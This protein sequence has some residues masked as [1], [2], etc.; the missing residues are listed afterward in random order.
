MAGSDVLSGSLILGLILALVALA[1]VAGLWVMAWRSGRAAAG[2]DGAGTFDLPWLN[3]AA[4]WRGHRVLRAGFASAVRQLRGVLRGADWRY[5]IPWV[6]V[7]GGR[8]SGRSTLVASINLPRQLALSPDTD[9]AELGCTWNVFESGIVLEPG[10]AMLWKGL[11]RYGHAA[12]WRELMNLLLR[13]RRERGID[14]VVITVSAAELTTGDVDAALERARQLREYLRELQQYLGLRVPA[15]LVVTKCDLVPGFAAFWQPLAAERGG[16]MFG[17]SNDETL[18]TAYGSQLIPRAFDDLGR[19][20]HRILLNQ[21]V[22]RDG[23]ADLA[24]LFPAE[25]QKLAEPVG[26]FADRLFHIDAFQDPH[27]FRGV[28]FTGDVPADPPAVTG[29]TASGMSGMAV[30][31]RSLVIDQIKPRLLFVTDLFA[32]K[33]FPEA[34]LVQPA[35]GG[36]VA[37]GRAMRLRWAGLALAAVILALGSWASYR[38]VTDSAERI[39]PTVQQIAARNQADQASIDLIHPLVDAFRAISGR[40]GR[41]IPGLG[42]PVLDAIRGGSGHGLSSPFLPSS[43]FSPIEEKVKAALIKGFDSMVIDPIGRELEAR[44]G[45]DR[46]AHAA[47]LTIE[48]DGPLVRQFRALADTVSYTER[49]RFSNPSVAAGQLKTLAQQLRQVRLVFDAPNLDWR[50][51]LHPEQDAFWAKQLEGIRRNRFLGDPAANGLM[52]VLAA[53]VGSLR[54]ALL[55]IRASETGPLVVADEKADGRLRLDPALVALD[56]A[57]PPVLAYDFLANPVRQLVNPSPRTNLVLWAPEPL[58]RAVA[59]E[60]SFKEMEAG[61]LT[62]VPETLRTMIKAVAAQALQGAMVSAVADAEVLQKRGDEF[63][64]FGDEDTLLQ[65]ARQFGRVAVPLGKVLEALK[66]R[67]FD[68]AHAAI[69]GVI[70]QHALA[71]LEQADHLLDNNGAWLPVE[72]FRGWDGTLPMNFEGYQV[73]SDAELD[74]YLKTAASRIDWLATEIAKPVVTALQNDAVPAPL[75]RHQR[76]LRWMRIL[77]ELERYKAGNPA[78]SLGELERF[79]KNDLAAVKPGTCLDSAAGAGTGT[80]ADFFAQ[81][82]QILRSMAQTQ[83]QRQIGEVGKTDFNRVVTEFNTNLAGR[84]PFADGRAADGPEAPPDAVAAFFAGFNPEVEARVRRGLATAARG[85]P[86]IEALRFVDQLAAVRD[87]MTPLVGATAANPPAFDVEAGFRVNRQRETGGNQIIEWTLNLGEQQLMRGGEAKTAKWRP[88]EPVTLRL[89]WAKDAPVAPVAVAGAGTG[90]AIIDQDRALVVSYANQWGLIRLLQNH[91]APATDLPGLV[92]GQPETLKFS[93]DTGN[94][95]V[96]E[97]PKTAK[98]LLK[99]RTN[100]FV[101]VSV[102]SVGADGKTRRVLPLPVFPFNAPRLEGTP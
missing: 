80:K 65:E 74:Q 93:A 73:L 11:T 55:A 26:R 67:G 53:K 36:M 88:G 44:A 79:I 92:D 8:E 22:Y 83:C 100:V 71:M 21:A 76:V 90:A 49:A 57:L 78:S 97:A 61:P 2:R 20:L 40:D 86:A 23:V 10:Q 60:A 91:R 72:E 14:G 68:Q 47:D 77:E 24:F 13:Y 35:R 38:E 3:A 15:Y 102:L 48:P 39:I 41:G 96:T 70:A 32:E 81:R 56:Q 46:L 28:Y 29:T 42:Y 45:L 33:V 84:Y 94:V 1:T 58:E 4:G 99:S 63:R 30:R 18:E 16:Q 89:R 25:F 69:A 9:Q 7:L 85:R 87:F 31:G 50:F 27:F 95:P 59:Y 34:Q 19:G 5:S 12:G 43:W 101:R 64:Q 62:R 98:P 37:R 6:L 52:S 17:W 66:A 75:R 54:T 82:L 51:V